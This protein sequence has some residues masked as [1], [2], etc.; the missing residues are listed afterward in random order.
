MVKGSKRGRPSSLLSFD[1]EELFGDDGAEASSLLPH[2]SISA[3]TSQRFEAEHRAAG[4]E[5]RLSKKSSPRGIPLVGE[6][7]N[8]AERLIGSPTTCSPWEEALVPGVSQ[9]PS[10]PLVAIGAARAR[11]RRQY[12][13]D[14]HV[15]VQD[16]GLIDPRLAG[17]QYL[18]VLDGHGGSRCAD[19]MAAD[20]HPRL[21]S[22]MSTTGAASADE[23]RTAFRRCFAA[24][25]S[26]FL[27]VAQLE[28][29]ADGATALCLLL[30]GAVAHVAN[31]GDT[32]AV[33]AR[34]PEASRI[35]TEL[36][37]QLTCD[38]ESQANSGL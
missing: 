29:L 30:H 17:T 18:C 9:P 15:I 38:V 21:A 16:L 24:S 28:A 31:I 1:E 13:E 8:P 5:K 35:D 23:V 2:K 33:L 32:R 27:Q 4:K 36:R 22:D 25:D 7:S 19:F 20:L 37:D 34:R 14:R 12:M 11:G 26:A 3:I 6:L 10:E